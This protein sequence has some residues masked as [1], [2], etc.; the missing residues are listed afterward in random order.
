MNP[1]DLPKA[2]LHPIAAVITV[3]RAL[4]SLLPILVVVVVT[5]R[6]EDSPI[7]I[8]GLVALGA[9]LVEGIGGWLRYH[10]WV[11]AGE[12][13]VERGF[14]VRQRVAIPAER[15]QTVDTSA[16]VLQ[17]LFGL[18]QIEIKT[19]AG[20]Q[21][22]MSAVTEA[23]AVALRS[24]LAAQPNLDPNAAAPPEIARYELSTRELLLAAST[25][26]RLGVILS[27]MAW[28]YSQVDDFIEERLLD[29][30]GT[31]SLADSV[32]RV[33]PL[34]IAATVLAALLIAFMASVVAEVA[35]FGGFSVVRTGD[36][37]VIRRGLFERREV[38]VSLDR[39]QA[40]RIVEGLLRQPLGY[41]AIIVETAGHAEERGQSTPLH[42][43]LHK[44][45]WRPLLR[46]LAPG[47]DIQPELQRPPRRALTRFVLRPCL[48]AMLLA[49]AISVSVPFGWLSFA[50]VLGAPWLG[51]LAFRDAAA[52]VQ[53]QT[54]LLTRRTL[55]RTT[56]IVRRR[57]IQ[58][59]ES[60]S[61]WFQRRRGLADF[62]V[63]VASGTRWQTLQRARARRRGRGRTRS[64]ERPPA[65]NPRPKPSPLA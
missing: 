43:F 54:L 38:S 25:S 9:S 13:R 17:R 37:L 57:R 59:S 51:W 8:V 15:V 32:S 22:V 6:V 18:V 10:Y 55:R 47:H 27:G 50:V 29:A 61:S 3:L 26:G 5:G 31:L 12:L 7:L 34:M 24:A 23:A 28:L 56:S 64:V 60:S 44:S 20:A 36:Q 52:G 42:P 53:D 35:R 65:K 58:F 62:T 30:L 63:A 33:S 14:F 1:S 49:G 4:R 41:A 39:I 16:G 21:V 46:Q 2:R 19:A 11:T 48:T 45:R 40:I